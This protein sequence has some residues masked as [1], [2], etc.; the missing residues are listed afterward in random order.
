MVL[1]KGGA[2]LGYVQ[3]D[4]VEHM[5]EQFWIRELRE[6]LVH[7]QKVARRFLDQLMT[8]G[9]VPPRS[10]DLWRIIIAAPPKWPRTS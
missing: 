6:C 4:L 2:M 8:V 10:R 9:F 3:W 1:K 5:S 7:D